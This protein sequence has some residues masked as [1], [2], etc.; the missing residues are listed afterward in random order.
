MSGLS[1]SPNLESTLADALQDSLNAEDM[2]AQAAATPAASKAI[3][4]A[5]SQGIDDSSLGLS[6]SPVQQSPFA[7]RAAAQGVSGDLSSA[8]A[9]NTIAADLR[10]TLNRLNTLSLPVAMATAK[11]DALPEPADGPVQ[12]GNAFLALT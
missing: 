3:A 6:P 7:A 11:S 1:A 2:A 8:E 10:R 4:N 12:V 5:V 9:D